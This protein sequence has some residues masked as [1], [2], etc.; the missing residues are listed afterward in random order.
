MFTELHF[1]LALP[2]MKLHLTIDPI[3]IAKDAQ[4]TQF[5][6]DI[7]YSWH[8]LDSSKRFKLTC[9]QTTILN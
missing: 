1:L 4:Q 7:I 5:C 9:S 8:D 6:P 3:C 2:I